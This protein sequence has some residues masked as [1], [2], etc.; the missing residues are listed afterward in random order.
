LGLQL[1][2]FTIWFQQKVSSYLS[3]IQDLLKQTDALPFGTYAF[4]IQSRNKIP[5]ADEKSTLGCSFIGHLPLVSF[6]WIFCIK[7]FLF[8]EAIRFRGRYPHLGRDQRVWNQL[9]SQETQPVCHTTILSHAP[10]NNLHIGQFVIL[11]AKSSLRP[12]PLDLTSKVTNSN[13]KLLIPIKSYQFPPKIHISTEYLCVS[14]IWVSPNV[15][16]AVQ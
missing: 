12:Q 11:H 8:I 4:R 2:A 9:V 10:L 1:S 3:Q 13:Q 7:S 14:N 5:E 6:A 16:R 15:I